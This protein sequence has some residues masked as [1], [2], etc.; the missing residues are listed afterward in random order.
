MSFKSNNNKK[1]AVKWRNEGMI[2]TKKNMLV[3]INSF[4][5]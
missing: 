1:E 5:Q 2:F 3:L 4:Q